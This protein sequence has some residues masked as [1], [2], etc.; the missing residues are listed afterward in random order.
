M[1]EEFEVLVSDVLSTSSAKII[2]ECDYCGCQFEN[3]VNNRHK[4]FKQ[5]STTLKDICKNKS[6]LENKI[7]ES[8]ITKYGTEHHITSDVVKDKIKNTFNEKYNVDNPFQIEEVK[9]KIKNTNIEKY[10]TDSFVRTDM[11]KL[12]TKKTNLERY[13]FEFATQSEDIKKKF[14]WKISGSNNYNWKGGISKENTLLRQSV[15]YKKWRKEVYERDN[16]TCQCCNQ[17]GGNLNAH[18]ISNFSSNENLRHDVSNGITL[19]GSCHNEFH[20]I[21]GK[22]ENNKLQLDEFISI[23]IKTYAELARN[24]V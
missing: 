2:I 12:K 13:G 24:E 17:K 3:T 6:C 7:K 5:N 19:C 21:Y 16:Y 10:G 14:V 18:H 4:A 8:N 20:K 22:K 11:Y 23:K 15:D 1:G 9:R